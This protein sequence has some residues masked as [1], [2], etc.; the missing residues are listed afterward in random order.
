MLKIQ[1]LSIICQLC[2]IS[3]RAGKL[4]E[5]M[6]ILLLMFSRF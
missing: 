6:K 4:D 3:F 1:I 5:I 2:E